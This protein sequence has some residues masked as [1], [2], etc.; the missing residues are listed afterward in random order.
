MS[1]VLNSHPANYLSHLSSQEITFLSRGGEIRSVAEAELEV[2]YSL[3]P[4]WL[5]NS[6]IIVSACCLK[7]RKKLSKLESRDQAARMASFLLSSLKENRTLPQADS[8]D[9]RSADSVGPGLD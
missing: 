4:I 3:Q 8:S 9:S 1:V 5:V 7:N 2:G 6:V